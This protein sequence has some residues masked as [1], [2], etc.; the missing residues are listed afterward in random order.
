MLWY[1][2]LLVFGWSIGG[3]QQNI[4]PRPR[5]QY[6][7]K[8]LQTVVIQTVDGRYFATDYVCNFSHILFCPTCQNQQATPPH[9]APQISMLKSALGNLR[10]FFRYNA[11]P[12]L[13]SH[14]NSST[15]KFG[16]MGGTKYKSQTAH[17]KWLA[18]YLPSTVVF[19]AVSRPSFL[20]VLTQSM[21]KI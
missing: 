18:K 19:M 8:C 2:N 21:T 16:G 3:R 6:F 12:K 17:P 20:S 14:C 10:S 9:P 7:Q 4:Q 13:A 15:L 5:S 11:P 1:H